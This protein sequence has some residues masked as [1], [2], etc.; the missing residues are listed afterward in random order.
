MDEPRVVLVRRKPADRKTEVPAPVAGST[1]AG[2]S[3]LNKLLKERFQGSNVRSGALNGRSFSGEVKAVEGDYVIQSLGRDNIVVHRRADL[4]AFAP[5]E[6]EKL[7]ISYDSK[8]FPSV[9][10]K[11][12]DKDL[13]KGVTR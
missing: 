11:D 9:K 1:A 13:L 4:A 6:G 5:R 10:R 7:N 8:G 2:Q 12:L 3:P